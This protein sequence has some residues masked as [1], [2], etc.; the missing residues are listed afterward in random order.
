MFV[1]TWVRC[2]KQ[3]A[4]ILLNADSSKRERERESKIAAES[5]YTLQTLL[6]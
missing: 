2:L 6:V 1:Q 5:T 3:L 4:F